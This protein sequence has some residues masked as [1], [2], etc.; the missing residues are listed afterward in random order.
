RRYHGQDSFWNL[1]F[2]FRVEEELYNLATDSDCLNNMAMDPQYAQLKTDLFATL[3]SEL[4]S[5]GDPRIAGR[6][7]VFDN[8][9][10]AEERVRN[11][12]KRFSAGEAVSAGWVNKDDFEPAHP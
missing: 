8:Y 4:E 3:K 6:G 12:H 5:E 11:F 7:E 2:G 9:P 10:Y 1:N